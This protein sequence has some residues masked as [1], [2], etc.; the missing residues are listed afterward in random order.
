MSRISYSEDEDRPGQFELWQANCQRSLSGRNGQAAL[1]ELEAALLALPDKR[2]VA[3][4]FDDGENVCAIGALARF[5]GITPKA[6]P[7]YEMEEVGVECGMPRMVAW[8][9]V[10]MNDMQFDFRYVIAEGPSRYGQ[11]GGYS[12]H[13]PYTAEER[14]TLILEWVRKQRAAN[15]T[16]PAAEERK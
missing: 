7:E 5:K 16:A 10:E 2:L 6:D 14:Y 13:V 11:S 8:K 15:G 1:A 12:M 3:G 9:V 4:E